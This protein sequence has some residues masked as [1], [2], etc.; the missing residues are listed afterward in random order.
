MS[1][2]KISSGHIEQRGFFLRKWYFFTTKT[3]HFVLL[4]H[5]YQEAAARRASVG[6]VEI[7][8]EAER[9]LWWTTSGLF[10]ADPELSD[11]DVALLI[12]DRQR[13]QD[14]RLDRLRKIRDRSEEIEFA[15]RER[16]PDE[17]PRVRVGA[18]RRTLCEVR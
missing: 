5:K 2:R 3:K 10:W 6:A 12:W 16:I 7:G 11:E 13:R 18:R 17:V 14:S 9:V 4:D 15:R 1:L 8:R